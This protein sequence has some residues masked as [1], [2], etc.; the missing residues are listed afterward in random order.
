MAQGKTLYTTVKTGNDRTTKAE[1]EGAKVLRSLQT[2]LEK[3]K[4]RI[5]QLTREIE[6]CKRSGV[7]A[8]N[9]EELYRERREAELKLMT[10]KGKFEDVKAS[11]KVKTDI[12]SHGKDFQ[13]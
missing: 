4:D 3:G 11:L 5:L 7:D 9:M 6:Q 2:T 10:A 12:F 8:L 1:M 13:D